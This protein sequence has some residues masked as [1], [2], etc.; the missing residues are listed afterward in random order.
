ML[1]LYLQRNKRTSTFER[2]ISIEKRFRQWRPGYKLFQDEQN[3]SFE[4]IVNNQ[5]SNKRELNENSNNN[6]RINNF[7]MKDGNDPYS[8]DLN[9]LI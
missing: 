9:Q 4:G 1:K 6:M 3:N 8:R 5:N 7:G 2:T